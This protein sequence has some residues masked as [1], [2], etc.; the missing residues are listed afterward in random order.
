MKE[1]LIMKMF[2]WIAII[3]F[4]VGCSSSNN[5]PSNISLQTTCT[6]GYS[7]DGGPFIARIPLSGDYYE[8]VRIIATNNNDY[9]VNVFNYT[10]IYYDSNKDEIGSGTIIAN[11]VIVSDQSVTTYNTSTETIPVNSYACTVLEWSQL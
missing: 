1:H 4:L 10:I 11:Q 5:S 2:S 7:Y 9:P 3:L 8:M 6:I